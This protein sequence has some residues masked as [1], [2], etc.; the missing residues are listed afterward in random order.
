LTTIT[1]KTMWAVLALACVMS[2]ALPA[3]AVALEDHID[4]FASFSG[5]G[6][7]GSFTIE[8]EPTITCESLDVEHG[9]VSVTGTTGS[10]T[11]DF[12]GCHTTVFGLTSKC[13]TAGS[14][15]DN[16]VITSGTFHVIAYEHYTFK[17][18]TKPAVLL[19]LAATTIT[20]SGISSM[21][22][23]GDVI[24]TIT[25]PACGTE[26][27]QLSVKF[28]AFGATQEDQLYTG[29]TH[30]LHAGTSGGFSTTGGLSQG[31]T[32]TTFTAGRLTC[33]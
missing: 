2:F 19:T 17:I 24:G 20:C 27:T 7:A 32:F 1:N 14:V 12:T 31:M 15:K 18:E 29:F 25:S 30:V 8:A 9:T 3:S 6:G 28:S 5:T 16:T 21:S 13:R 26:S 23:S 11:L 33:T 4:G 10:M 22:F